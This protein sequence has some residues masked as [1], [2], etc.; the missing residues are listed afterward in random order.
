M[1]VVINPRTNP[2]ML[3]G[4]KKK[5]KRTRPDGYQFSGGE[6]RGKEPVA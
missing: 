6:R 3:Q 2:H 1:M 4:G 5:G